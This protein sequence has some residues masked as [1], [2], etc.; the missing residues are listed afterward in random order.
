MNYYKS[1]I[2]NQY[3]SAESLL[4][5]MRSAKSDYPNNVIVLYP[6]AF[7]NIPAD[8]TINGTLTLSECI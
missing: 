4:I 5:A 1:N 8:A 7:E 3:Y 6:I 2:P